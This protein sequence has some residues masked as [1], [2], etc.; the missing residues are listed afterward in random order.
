MNPIIKY[1]QLRAA[2]AKIVIQ[3]MARI[4]PQLNGHLRITDIDSTALDFLKNDW[5]NHPQFS[6]NVG[7]YDDWKHILR[8]YRTSC[9]SRIEAAIWHDN[10][11]CALLLGKCSRKKYIARITYL[12]G[13]YDDS[14]LAGKR[15]HIAT[16]YLELF[17][18][19]NKIEW[20]GIQDPYEG[21]EPLYRFRGF[22]QSDPFDHN[23]DSLC[24][25][26]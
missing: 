25:Q 1:R 5:Q 6:R 19:A 17:A 23:N 11:L 18:V 2:T 21:A 22:T 24:K 9:S 20:V 7:T 4:Y 16:R 15:I 10:H 14:F 12:Q 26:L 3:E 8:Q 13:N